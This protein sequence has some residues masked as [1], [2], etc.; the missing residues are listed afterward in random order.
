MSVLLLTLAIVVPV[1]AAEKPAPVPP[2]APAVSVSAPAAKSASGETTPVAGKIAAPSSGVETDKSCTRDTFTA[3][4]VEVVDH[5]RL[6]INFAW[7][8]LCGFLVMFMQVGFALV[9]TG[10]CRA[11]NASHTMAMNMMIYCIGILGF[12]ACGF[13]IQ[14]GGVGNLPTLGGGHALNGEFTLNLFGKTFGVFGTKGFFL[15]G[16]TFDMAVFAAF[17]FQMV[18]MDTAATIPTG[19]MA[20]RFKFS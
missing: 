9:E 10:L 2:Q 4:L 1:Y 16:A 11:K 7:T 13:A 8:L 19:A 18:F 15:S 5:N 14:M 17:L 20:E 6:S 12:W 3:K